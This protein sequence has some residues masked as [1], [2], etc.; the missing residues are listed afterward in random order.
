MFPPAAQE[1]VTTVENNI[2][3]FRQMGWTYG[4]FST[5]PVTVEYSAYGW[6]RDLASGPRFGTWRTGT[7]VTGA[8][9]VRQHAK[10]SGRH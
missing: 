10:Q 2:A 9:P 7:Q 8:L 6:R 5:L 1:F 3:V 4:A